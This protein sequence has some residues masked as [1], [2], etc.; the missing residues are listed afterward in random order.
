MK[1]GRVWRRNILYI[2]LYLHIALGLSQRAFLM[3]TRIGRSRPTKREI[4]LVV[5]SGIVPDR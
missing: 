5:P 2:Q 3:Y 1:G 4:A